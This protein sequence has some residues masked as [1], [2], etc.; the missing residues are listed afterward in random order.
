ML[1]VLKAII[2]ASIDKLVLMVSFVLILLSFDPIHYQEKHFDFYLRAN[3]N[4]F[5]FLPGIVLL[6]FFLWQNRGKQLGIASIKNIDNGYRLL[7]DFNHSISVVTGK[8]EDFGG[9]EH[10]AVVLPANTSFDDQCIRDNRTALGSFFLRH[11]PTGVGEIQK[12]IRDEAIKDL[13]KTGQDFISAPSGTTVFLDK[14]FGSL[15]RVMVTAVTTADPDQ[16]I[17]ADT[18][19]LLASLK[20]VFKMASQKRISS[21][22]MP[23]MGTGHGGLD[24]KA[25]LSLIL[26]QCMHSMQHEEARNVRDVTIIVYDPE[27]HKKDIINKVIQSVGSLSQI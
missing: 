12:L 21:L 26:V 2:D 1:K 9:G 19:S 15:F 27:R 3:P 20:Q 11:F 6:F 13:G 8:I 25:A 22:T 7:F 23:V 17:T 5:L 14:P 18:L 16:G 24:F 10:A 4:L